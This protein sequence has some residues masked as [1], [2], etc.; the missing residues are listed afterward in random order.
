MKASLLFWLT[1]LALWVA[2]AF[3]IFAALK[4]NKLGRQYRALVSKYLS[5]LDR[6]NLTD[7]D[8]KHIVGQIHNSV[9]T[10][11]DGS[12]DVIERAKTDLEFLHEQKPINHQQSDCPFCKTIQDLD[13]L[14]AELRIFADMR[15]GR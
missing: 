15:I 12:R 2:C 6:K 7:D 5:A 3:N 10:A 8:A 14:A 9:L 4:N 13:G 1:E 11:M